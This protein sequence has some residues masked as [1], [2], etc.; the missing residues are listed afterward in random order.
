MWFANSREEI[1][2]WGRGCEGEEGKEEELNDSGKK[3]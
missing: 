2:P 3:F 1:K